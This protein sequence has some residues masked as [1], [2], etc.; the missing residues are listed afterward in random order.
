MRDTR[1]SFL[2]NTSPE[3]GMRLALP[4][5]KMPISQSQGS[6]NMLPYLTKGSK[7]VD[8]LWLLIS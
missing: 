2:G 6:L 7:G 3:L 8:M 4:L 5:P 1:I